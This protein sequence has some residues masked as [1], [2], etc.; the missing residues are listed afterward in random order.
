[1]KL[2]LLKNSKFIKVNIIILAVLSFLLG[3]II[4]L[5]R[6]ENLESAILIRF[7]PKYLR[8]WDWDSKINVITAIISFFDCVFALY[9]LI[10]LRRKNAP[11]EPNKEI[12]EIKKLI[13]I[14]FILMIFGRLNEGLYILFE[15]DFIATLDL[16]GEFYILLDFIIVGIFTSIIY[17]MFENLE[18]VKKSKLI[19]NISVFLSILLYAGF[20][21][22]FIFAYNNELFNSLIL[23]SLSIYILIIIDIGALVKFV[24]IISYLSIE[25]KNELKKIGIILIILMLCIV[26]IIGCGFFSIETIYNKLPNRIFRIL[27]GISFLLI[28]I[29]SYDLFI[30]KKNN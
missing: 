19:Q 26:F 27:R 28:L 14:F 10:L 9:I 15:S 5:S 1:M 20:F 30:K 4:D 6:I 21:F 25:N 11:N 24:F 29:I 8:I 17:Y 22:L 18:P 3:I 2:N 12:S 23:L 7:R 13:N 16:F